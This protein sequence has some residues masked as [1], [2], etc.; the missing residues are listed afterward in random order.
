MTGFE[1]LL[2]GLLSLVWGGSFFFN[3][4]LVVELHPFTVVFFRVALAAA[5]LLVVLRIT[6]HSLPRSARLWGSFFVMG[7]LNNLIP[8]GLI[9]WGQTQIASGLAAI[10]NATTPLFTAL[11]VHFLA[12]DPRERLTGHRLLGVVIGLVGVVLIVGPASLAGL[13]L[14]LLA[15]VAVLGAAL[16]YGFANNFGRRFRAA[17]VPPLVAATGQVSATTIMSLPLMLLIDRPWEL[18]AFPSATTIAALVGLALL[19][20]SLAY[21]IFFRLLSGAGAVNVA[22]VTLLVPASA[23]LL[24]A[25]VFGERLDWHQLAGMA[26]ILAGLVVIDGRLPA[27]LGRRLWRGDSRDP[28]RSR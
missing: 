26:V 5:A 18:P 15:Q 9:V 27:A 12:Q 2:L 3:R 13:G 14:N 1:W 8:F 21:V 4:V 19:S 28:L 7:L 25:L 23:L 24:G 6:G 17:G 22:L 20:T 11:I 10:L 16:S